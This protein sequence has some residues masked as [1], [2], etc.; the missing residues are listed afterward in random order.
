MTPGAV[1][2]GDFGLHHIV[3]AEGQNRVVLVKRVPPEDLERFCEQR[4]QWCRESEAC[5]GDDR[6]AGDD[7]RTLSIKYRVNG[8]RSRSFK[9]SVQELRVVDFDDFPFNPRTCLEYVK[10]VSNVAESALAQHTMWVTQSGIPNGD[11]AIWEDDV[12]ARVI[13]LALKFDGLNIANLASFELLVRRRQLIAAHAY[14]PSAPTYEAADHF[15]QVGHRPGGAIVVQSLT[16]HVA[17]KLH[18]EGQ[19]LKERRKLREEKG[20][21]GGGALTIPPPTLRASPV[22]SRPSG[23]D[24]R[25]RDVF[26]LPLLPVTEVVAKKGLS[27]SVRR[28]ILRRDA[29]GKRANM[30]IAL[31][32]EGKGELEYL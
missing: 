10:E 5:A 13:D 19:I 24:G 1:T 26:P 7:A 29:V 31:S 11:R 28:R 15:L 17:E 16:K 22:F 6:V 25:Q 8:E 12:L 14:S 27:R 23:D 9:E 32:G 2:D 21:S 20:V 30:A 18:Q 3:D 4:I